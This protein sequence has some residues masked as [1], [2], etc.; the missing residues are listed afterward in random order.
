[1]RIPGPQI[2]VL[3]PKVE[4]VTSNLVEVRRIRH[5]SYTDS[6]QTDHRRPPVLFRLVEYQ[7]DQVLAQ[8]ENILHRH[9]HRRKFGPP[10]MMFKRDEE[11]LQLNEIKA[12][13]PESGDGEG[14]EEDQ[15]IA[16]GW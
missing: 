12:V 3:L 13:E 16:D 6:N 14:R 5:P 10:R 7:H 1:M 2:V 9:L 15:G 4:D 11:T 8:V